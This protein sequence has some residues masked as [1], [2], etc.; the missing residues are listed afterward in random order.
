MRKTFDA[1]LQELSAEMIDM[2]AAAEDA[3]DLVTASLAAPDDRQAREAISLTHTMD[4]TERDIENR[5]LRLLL[6]QQPV[7]RD[8]RT[9]SAALKMVTDLQRIGDQCANIAEISLL[10]VR[11]PGGSIPSH[12]REMSR[13]AGYMVKRAIFAYANRDQNAAGEVI[14]LDDAV[15]EL[16][17]TVKGDL[18]A[19]IRESQDNADRAIDLIIIAKYL[20]RIADHAVNIAQWAIYC[21]TGTLVDPS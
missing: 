13:K 5:C 17:R 1:E 19:L 18:V 11:E 12:I 9:I 8:L 4:Q 21:V 10:L 14:G 6:Q 2:A 16:F 7:A 15:D 3:I 20:E